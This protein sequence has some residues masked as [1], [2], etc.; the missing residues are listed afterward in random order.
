MI[1]DQT[2]ERRVS[3]VDTNTQVEWREALHPVLDRGGRKTSRSVVRILVVAAIPEVSLPVV[4]RYRL[5]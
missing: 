4:G 3:E 2:F 1:V 5:A